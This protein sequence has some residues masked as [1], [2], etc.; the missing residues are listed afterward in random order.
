MSP[1]DTPGSSSAPLLSDPEE[2]VIE[3]GNKWRDTQ[4]LPNLSELDGNAARQGKMSPKF[5]D[6]MPPISPT[7]SSSSESADIPLL[8]D[9]E[10]TAVSK[11]EKFSEAPKEEKKKSFVKAEYKIALS[12]FIVRND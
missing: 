5:D 3:E 8:S 2:T 6:P 11:D 7:A 4:H 12:H 1:D 10:D 9:T